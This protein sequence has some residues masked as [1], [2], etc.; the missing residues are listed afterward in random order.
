[1]TTATPAP[2]SEDE[3]FCSPQVPVP[4]P[5]RPTPCRTAQ[6]AFDALYRKH[7]RL[8]LAFLSSRVPR[9][10]LDDVHQTVWGRVWE[11]LSLRDFAAATSAAGCSHRQ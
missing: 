1:M 5:A 11:Y 7:A 10:D 4:R 6:Q 3:A 8:L 9:H 2:A